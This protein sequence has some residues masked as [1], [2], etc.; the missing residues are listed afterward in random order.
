M[1][2]WMAA[3][4]GV[5]G[6][7]MGTGLVT[8][9][10]LNLWQAIVAAVVGSVGSFVF[11]ALI[12]MSGPLSGAPAMVASR[13]TF[14]MRG[15][16]GPTIMSWIVLAGWE[17]AMC[18]TATLA[19]VSVLEAFGIPTVVWITAPAAVLLVAG[20]A[21]ISYFGHAT[22]MWVQQWLGWVLGGL[23]LVV[24]IVAVTTIDW[25]AVV[26][27]P[28]GDFAA[29]LGGIGVIAAGTGVGWFSAS[30]DY[31]RYLPET[32]RLSRVLLV[33]LVGAAV[34]LVVLVST[35]SILAL[36]AGADGVAGSG[37]GAIGL[38][39][40]D[41]LLVPYLITAM[42]GLLT[43]ADLSMYSSA[44]NLQAAGLPL[45]R[46]WA[47]VVN[48]VPITLITVYLTVFG[49]DA[50]GAFTTAISVFALPLAAWVGVFGVD[51]LFRRK[52]SSEDLLDGT[53][54]SAYWFHAGFHWPAIGAWLLAIILGL[55]ST[56]VKVGA[57]VWFSGPLADTWVGRNS[58]GWLVAG[59]SASAIYWVLQPLTAE[60][61]PGRAHPED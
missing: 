27:A 33:T 21:A 61:N 36:G 43:A 3:N 47:V 45:S 19:L 59:I 31:T 55:L 44:L 34:P 25:A 14:G 53:P 54:E 60:H 7:T 30:G 22:I 23:T 10:G 24:C 40:P 12:S 26:A 32:V 1:W 2:T 28:G 9:L 52:I 51:L 49:Q 37:V 41:W 57:S 6:I 20:S 39:L 35:G 48:A 4:I 56:R 11:V 50:F 5:L 15:N 16:L 42:L 8:A 46:R 13:A 29:V 58:L 18:T 38:V 17:V